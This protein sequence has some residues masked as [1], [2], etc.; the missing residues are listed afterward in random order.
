MKFHEML[1]K[2]SAIATQMRALNDELKNEKRGFSDEEEKR[3]GG[4]TKELDD[5]E[6]SIKREEEIRGV[7][8]TIAG[9]RQDE[10]RDNV[11]PQS[12]E[13]RYQ[14]AFESLCRRGASDLT[15]DEKQAIG[16]MRAL[17]KGTGSQGGFTVPVE[18][19][20][21]I[22]ESMKVYGGIAN[23]CQ[24][25]NTSNGNPME[26]NISDGR[27]EIGEMLGENTE[28]SKGDPS[29][30]KISLGAKK[31]SSKIILV[32]N[33]L[34]QD[35]AVDIEGLIA[36]RVGSRIG[37]IEAS[38][39]VKGDGTGNNVNGLLNQVVLNH[40][41]AAATAVS[42]EDLIELKHSVD[43]AYRM[44]DSN[45]FIFNDNTF[46]GLKLLKDSQNRP[47][48][49]PAISGVAP[50]TIDGDQFEID[51]SM[52]SAALGKAST[53]YGDFQ[54]YVL[55]RVQYMALRRLTERYA[56]FDQ[57]GFVAFHRFDGVLED[58]AA[59]SKL[60]HA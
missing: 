10:Q 56:E 33:E 27:T 58:V 31:A 8:E 6:S 48:W 46:K 53:M 25:I 54:S 51:Q 42:Y 9:Q 23:V 32:S 50:A 24:I 19:R 38:Q 7:D 44:G 15:S 29:F 5:L 43:P 35:S 45:R 4:M 59:I 14:G 30:G 21:R 37:R 13:K 20:N 36:R 18:F 3:W 22:V 17:N 39:I 1:Q 55:R 34:L 60:T 26:W 40:V 2:R 47:L 52:D 28:A 57:M 12:L 41:A 16:E 49:L 11:D